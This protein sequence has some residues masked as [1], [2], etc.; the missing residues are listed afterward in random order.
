M[1]VSYHHDKLFIDL[2]LAPTTENNES[3]IDCLILLPSEVYFTKPLNKHKS[4]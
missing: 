4:M 1:L 2:Q 3:G